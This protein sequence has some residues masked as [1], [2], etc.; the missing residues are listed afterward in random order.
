MA[1][2][3]VFTTTACKCI[4]QLNPG[5]EPSSSSARIKPGSSVKVWYVQWYLLRQIR[6]LLALSRSNFAVVQ[7]AKVNTRDADDASFLRCLRPL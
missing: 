6:E 4:L 7:R 5:L 1:L 2:R 3:N